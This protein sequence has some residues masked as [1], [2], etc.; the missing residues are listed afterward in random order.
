MSSESK[1]AAV[2]NQDFKLVLDSLLDAYR[3]ILEH[4]LR[5]AES[6]DTLLQDTNVNPP[7]CE[8]EIAVAQQLFQKFF[9]PEVATSLLPVE[10]QKAFGD[11]DEW[12]WC[13]RHILC[14]MV[15]GWL[16]CRGPRTFRG[17]AYYLYQ[18]WLCVRQAI[19][20]PVSN[21]PTIA[22]KR[23]FS[24]LVRL[25]A[26]AYAPTVKGEL[27]DL[28]YPIDIPEEIASGAIDCDSGNADTGAIF[29][30]L[31]APDAAAALFGSKAAATLGNNNLLA[32]NCR[33]YCIAALEF[34]C[35]LARVYTLREAI[36]CLKVYFAQLRRCFNPLTAEIDAPGA[37]S[38]L[39]FVPACSLAGIEVSGTAAGAAF[40]SYTLSYSF[41]GPIVNTAVVYPDCSTPPGSPSSAIPV[42]G[43]VLGYLNVD[44]L[45]PGVTSITVYLDVYG[46]GGL[47][48][49]VSA[50][51]SYAVDSIAITGIATLPAAYA[52]D[53]FST[54]LTPPSIK[55]IPDASNPGFEKSIGGGV[56]ITG[57]ADAQGCGN[58]MTQY[59]LA[60]FGPIV[61]AEPIPVPNPSV[62]APLT[63]STGLDGVPIITPVLYN[64]PLTYPMGFCGVSGANIVNN[65]NLDAYWGTSPCRIS[66]FPPISEA[67]P[68]LQYQ[69]WPTPASGRYL[70]YLE[71]DQAPLPSLAPQ[72]PA[73]ED[74][75]TVWIDNYEVVVDLTA[76]GDVIG[77]GDL[78]LS[79]YQNP[80]TKANIPAIIQGVAWDFPIDIKSTRQ[81][82]N[83]NFGSYLL[84]FQKNGGSPVDFQPAEYTPN[85]VPG[86]PTVRVPNLW[87]ATA[88]DPLT[89]SGILASWD[90]VAALDGGVPT[91]PANPCNPPAATPWQIP[92]GCHCAYTITLYVNDNTWVGNGGDNHNNFKSFAV[93]IINDL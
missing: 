72:T 66:H 10:G 34:G 86:T 88:P 75:V 52:A 55:L 65:G 33:C 28:E 49:Q 68:A 27:K 37:C 83:E 36:E 8:D 58:Q 64:P 74:S 84:T 50:V 61:G 15:F 77:C 11:V 32:R 18:Y 41:G 69:N 80:V 6:A 5:L 38:S 7:S 19:G 78:R 46:S 12:E 22:D 29:E 39:T 59:Q 13:Y 14:C 82:P 17:F 51:F 23:D 57:S 53:P 45:P 62:T 89:Q 79:Q 56:V 71:V 63:S 44:L 93:T 73:G 21:P 25:L 70:V 1:N 92:R 42:S 43:G 9:T 76:I 20:E 3:P 90:I 40:T 16:V 47:H 24:T 35:C 2:S 4:E 31:L 26:T 30:R 60:S 67:E 87:S 91:D 48:L 85:G 54:S 81:A